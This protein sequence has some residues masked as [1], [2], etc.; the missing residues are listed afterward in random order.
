MTAD[1]QRTHLVCAVSARTARCYASA[2]AGDKTIKLWDGGDRREH[3]ESQRSTSA[4]ILCLAFRA[5]TA[6]HWPRPAG[7]PSDPT[8]GRG[9]GQEQ[10]HPAARLRPDPLRCL[11][12]GRQNAGGSGGRQAWAQTKGD[13]TVRLWAPASQQEARS[14]SAGVLGASASWP[15][16]RTTSAGRR[17]P[18]WSDQ[19]LSPD[20]GER[21]ALR[22]EP[23]GPVGFRNG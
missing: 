18:G 2:G 21:V 7:E 16:A 8:V 20:G 17:E 5:R 14:F 1:P 19:A 6:R 15:S 22:H 9:H 23:A 11:Q 3:P 4:P 13:T 12:P 10:D